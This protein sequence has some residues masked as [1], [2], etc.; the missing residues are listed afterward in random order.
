MTSF[1]MMRWDLVDTVTPIVRQILGTSGL[2]S[3]R[4]RITGVQ[5]PTVAAML[6][7]KDCNK[8]GNGGVR[9]EIMSPLRSNSFLYLRSSGAT[10]SIKCA[11]VPLLI[12]HT[13][14]PIQAYSQRDSVISVSNSTLK[15]HRE[16]YGLPCPPALFSG[17]HFGV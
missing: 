2:F 11:T 1:R 12:H 6:P 7:Q 3:R 10:F 5:F 8:G 17:L 9:C 13:C 15:Q 14:I 4:I 16:C